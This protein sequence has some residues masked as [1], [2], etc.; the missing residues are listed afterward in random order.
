MRAG[1][2][3]LALTAAIAFAAVA[4]AALGDGGE[5]SKI[6]ITKLSANGAKGKVTS[7]AH[8]CEGGKKVSLF[9]FD[10]YVSVKISITKSKSSGAWRVEEGSQARQVLRQ[11]R[12]ERRLPLRGLALQ[13]PCAD[14]R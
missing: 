2:T 10:D 8:S 13:E 11:G 3:T 4:P 14:S 5:K 6:K 12:R 1:L 9:R 7:K